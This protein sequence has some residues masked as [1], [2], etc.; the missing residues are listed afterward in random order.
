MQ[1]S[2]VCR[3]QEPA[4]AVSQAWAQLILLGHQGTLCTL[5]MACCDFVPGFLVLVT[6]DLMYAR[7]TLPLSLAFNS[8]S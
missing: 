3:Q 5:W 7:Y 1:R 4:Q 2:C 8:R 6:Q